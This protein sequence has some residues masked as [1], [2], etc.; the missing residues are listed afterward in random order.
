MNDL[1]VLQPVMPMSAVDLDRLNTVA[2]FCGDARADRG[3]IRRCPDKLDADEVVFVSSNVF[4][5]TDM[6]LAGGQA[7]RARAASIGGVPNDRVQISVIVE[8]PNNDA[9]CA[10]L[11]DPLFGRDQLECAVGFLPIEKRAD[12]RLRRS[13]CRCAHRYQNP[14]RLR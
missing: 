9:V 12:S 5:Q 7:M 3:T 6:S 2:D 1:F 14:A 11:G 4:K 8:I 13:G 10:R